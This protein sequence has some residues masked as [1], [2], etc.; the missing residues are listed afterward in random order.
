M[1]SR[2]G[3]PPIRLTAEQARRFIT[4]GFLELTPSVPAALHET[5]RRRLDTCVPDDDNP[6]NNVL[7]VVPEMRHILSS[8]EVHGALVSLLGPDYLEHPHRFCHVQAQ[9]ED[10]TGDYSQKLADNCHQDSYTPLAR[11]RH[12][13]LR[14]A[15]VMYYPQDTP[16]EHGPT[17]VIPG[18]Q[19]NREL[20]A[21]DRRHTIPVSG[22]AGTVSITHFDVGHAAGINRLPHR[23]FMVKFIFMRANAPT[24][25]GWSG[26]D[27]IWRQP[28]GGPA[29]PELAPG[30]LAASHLWDWL[31]G[32]SSR[33][34][35]VAGGALAATA[36][37]VSGAA[38]RAAAKDTSLPISRR[39]A[40]VEAMVSAHAAAAAVADLVQML[41]QRPEPLRSAATY[42]LG[43]IGEPAIG[44]LSER[45]MNS[46]E[47]ADAHGDAFGESAYVI[48]D[49]AHAMAAMGEVAVPAL[50]R[51]LESGHAWARTCAAFALGELDAGGQ[52][53]VPALICALEDPNHHVVR[54]VADALG[55][56]GSAEAATPLARILGSQKSQW[57]IEVR[58]GWSPG[59]QVRMNAANALARLGHKAVDAETALIAAL[60]DPCGQVGSS[61]LDALRRIGSPTALDAA[62]G[63]LTAA[64]WD[65]SLTRKPRF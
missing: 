8:P 7:P 15:R 60:D 4:D 56:I 30:A 11:P 17:H 53:A 14:F 39:V 34:A 12:H 64:R 63:A 33:Y 59:M 25:N 24:P 10:P 3:R 16:A 2:P 43:V 26:A 54:A 32:A 47:L 65:P 31:R 23:R 55:T 48:D 62:F 51:V 1:T 61:A 37:E 27:H 40:A 41:N 28:D 20:D 22:P 45:L 21:T 44:P 42:A 52:A 29:A 46:P 35:S 6:G 36:H 13:L 58:N 18:T 9:V 38:A 49:A 50:T 19:L 5:I 57:A